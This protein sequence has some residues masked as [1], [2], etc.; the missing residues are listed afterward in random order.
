MIT[1]LSRTWWGRMLANC[2]TEPTELLMGGFLKW[3][4]G[5]WL[6]LPLQSLQG[7]PTFSGLTEMLPEPV[8]GLILMVLGAT[9]MMSLYNGS[10]R[11]RRWSCFIS[12]SLWAGMT[13]YSLWVNPPAFGVT[14]FL[15]AAICQGWCCTR[16]QG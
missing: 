4:V 15:T 11:Y 6:M 8:W 10:I 14:L 16:L 12:M 1:Y 2:D 7:S 3:L 13:F 5:T 9:H